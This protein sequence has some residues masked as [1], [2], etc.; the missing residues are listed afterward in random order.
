MK[1]FAGL[2]VGVLF[3]IGM[4][5]A[6]FAAPSEERKQELS[7][8][9]EKIRNLQDEIAKGEETHDEAADGL[10][11]ADKAISAAQ[12]R[13]REVS[14]Q[15]SRAEEDLANLGVQRD[16]LERTLAE[17]RKAL[18]DAIFRIYV[19]GGQAGARR[20]L[21]GDEP[22]QLARDAYYLELIARQRMASI[23]NSRKALQDLNGV[24]A[25]VEAR[26]AELAL[27]EREHRNGQ[28]TL[29]SE[30]KKQ[31][32]TLAQISVQ[33]RTQRKQMQTLQQNESRIEKLLKGLER[34]SREPSTPKKPPVAANTSPSITKP[35]KHVTPPATSS[36]ATHV[37]AGVPVVEASVTGNFAALKGKLHWPVRGELNGRFGAQRA[38]GGAQWHGVFIRAGAG[39]DVKAVAAG[40]VAFADWLRGFGNLIIVDHGDGYMTV[41]G[42][43]EAL[44]KSP[45]EAVTAGEPIASVGASGGQDESGLYFEI[46]YR[47]QAQDP[48]KWAAGR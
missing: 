10:A 17:A 8:L 28:E 6:A 45:G 31:S 35:N 37:E 11:V 14:A 2:L 7:V 36:S 48:A 22:N 15:R 23:D 32:E 25:Q 1:R 38:E 30:R 18:G 9:K 5:S 12:R 4:L 34:I 24:I 27:L 26:K 40:K 41:Y 43:N 13:L 33:L 21:S 19:E 42:N 46:R 29:L 39:Q 20:F 47:G 44:F 16:E 3:G